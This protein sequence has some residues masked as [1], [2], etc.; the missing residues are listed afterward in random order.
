MML[1]RYLAVLCAP[2]FVALVALTA[3]AGKEASE[4]RPELSLKASPM[5]S[6]TPARI[7]FSAELRGGPDDFEEFYCPTVEWDWGDGTRSESTVDCEP[8]ERGRSEIVRRF[9]IQRVFQTAGNFRVQL[10]L[11]KNNKAVIAASTTVQVRAGYRDP[12]GEP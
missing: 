2:P 1:S 9:R 11:K 6:F 7:S 12:T 3:E 8:Y 5:I 4:K 10:R